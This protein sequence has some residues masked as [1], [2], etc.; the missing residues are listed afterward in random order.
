M[1]EG[2]DPIGGFVQP[3]RARVGGGADEPA[4]VGC[5]VGVGRVCAT[6]WL[7]EELGRLGRGGAY[8]VG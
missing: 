4:A 1:Q 6:N 5:G 8:H 2:R 7:G 3:G